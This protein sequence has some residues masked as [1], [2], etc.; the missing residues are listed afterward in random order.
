MSNLD[1]A[2]RIQ[3]TLSTPGWLDILTLLDEMCA[4]AQ[5]EVLHMM[6]VT[7]DKLTGKGAIRLASRAR[8]LRDFK[9]LVIDELKVLEPPNAKARGKMGGMT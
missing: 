5:G 9:D 1:R 3:A 4:E 2:R 7:P 8:A 6:S